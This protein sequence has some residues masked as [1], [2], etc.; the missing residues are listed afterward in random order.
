MEIMSQLHVY[1][2]STLIREL[3]LQSMDRANLN[4]GEKLVTNTTAASK[5][6]PKKSRIYIN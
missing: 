4:K 5:Y 2:N 1:F 6:I 3:R